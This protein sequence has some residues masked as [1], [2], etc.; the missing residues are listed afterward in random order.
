MRTAGTYLL[1]FF[2]TALSQLH[3]Q[4]NISTR[5]TLSHQDTLINI[6]LHEV[7]VIAQ[8]KYTSGTSSFIRNEAIQHIQP[9][10]L[11]EL[12]QLLPGGITPAVSF[13]DPGKFTI[14]HL[15]T[16][17]A[18][19][20]AQGTGIL[21]DG[22]RVN[23][24]ADL[25]E[26]TNGSAYGQSGPDTREISTDAIESVEV[27]RGI[28]SVRYGD[29]TTGMVIVNT[30]KDIRP[31]S[32]SIR[33]T[34]EIKAF[35]A[36]KG[37]TCGAS[38]ILNL[39]T[40][41]T[42]S[43]SDLS[44]ALGIYHRINIESAYIYRKQA[45]LMETGIS[46]SM[47]IHQNPE[48]LILQPGEYLKARNQSLRIRFSGTW[49][50]NLPALSN[51]RW[52]ASLSQAHSHSDANQYHSEVYTTGTSATGNTEQQGFFIPPQYWTRNQIKSNPLNA[53]LDLSAQLQKSGPNW[54]SQTTA[55]IGWNCD[56]N[57]GKGKTY[58]Y[59]TPA[60]PAKPAYN[61]RDIP[62]LH[63]YA[64]YLEE[65]FT[66]KR[67][68]FEGGI[69]ITGVSLRDKHFRPVAEP[70]F[71][72][73]Y[74]ALY[75]PHGQLRTLR[76]HFGAGI[77]RKMPALSYLYQEPYYKNIINYRYRDEENNRALAVL[78]TSRAELQGAD[79][80]QLPRNLKIE[81]GVA[82]IWGSFSFDIT[83]FYERLDKGF[84]TDQTVQP[85]A[86]RRYNNTNEP[87][88]HPEYK[89]GEVYL[90]GTPA[91][92]TS[93]TTF[94]TISVLNNNFTEYKGGIEFIFRSDYIPALAT[95]F[96]FDGS[97]LLVS[98]QTQG[99]SVTP[100][101]QV[102][103]NRSYPMSPFYDNSN[104]RNILQRFN[105]TLRAVTEIKALN[106]TTTVAFQSIW[107]EKSYE[108]ISNKNSYYMKD[109]DGSRIYHHLGKNAEST[110]YLDPVYYMDTRGYI[111]AFTPDLAADPA[112]SPM[113]KQIYGRRFMHN[114][115]SPYFLLNIRATKAIGQHTEITLFANN[116]A[117]MNPRRY[118]TSAGAYISM[119]PS[120]FFGAEIQIKL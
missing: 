2:L 99:T 92:Y 11:G 63:Y 64:A 3:A 32:I 76:L 58:E 8:E 77:L 107:M 47:T 57:L 66:T 94:Q 9:F 95:T 28:P 51:L 74:L 37:W 104:S 46:A 86:F 115:Y 85:V 93:D 39:N 72:F 100:V 65:N 7:E 15:G 79:Q 5:D 75:R 43:N 83:G 62:F 118:Q 56:G 54:K 59:H 14:R 117:K 111:H 90:N 116:L 52:K 18:P 119:N 73:S 113:V 70:R 87:G 88:L 41:Y 22:V 80:L 50:P 106:L 4:K 23:T 45:L 114:S 6:H 105:T 21:I 49:T 42:R 19:A 20:N 10:S 97:W 98:N 29:I 31:Y 27:I 16:S 67:I 24:N 112:Y 34:P 44:N 82:G 13:R 103:G 40:G 38:G 61:F 36:G 78:T 33:L 69:R 48:N 101:E 102:T 96:I 55:G 71:N 25:R 81:T 12:M 68:L 26:T 84:K 60:L 35:N 1:L 110:K 53:A 91:G 109:T 30:R 108:K 120:T 89:N 17:T